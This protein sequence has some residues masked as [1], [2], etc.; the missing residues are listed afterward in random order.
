VKGDNQAYPEIVDRDTQEKAL[1]AMLATIRP[2]AL[3]F[4]ENLLEIIPPRPAGLGGSRELFSGNT[5]PALDALGIAETAADLPVGL[6]LNPDRA[7]RLV[8]Y[9]ARTGNL[10][11]EEVLDELINTSWG[12]NSP[13]GYMGSVHRTVKH[14]VLKNMFEL[15]ASNS[16]SPLTKAIVH[17]KLIDLKVQLSLNMNE[18]PDSKYGVY[19]IDQFFANP[20]EFETK[21]AP[22]PP[23]G[24]PIGSDELLYCEF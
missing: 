5:G 1:N 13:D 9:S 4:P 3:A 14:V 8:E 11:L 6:I 10:S 20:S 17:D 12:Q 24:S 2:E 15:A 18:S 22:A 19:L 23:P 21:D 7:N 16:A